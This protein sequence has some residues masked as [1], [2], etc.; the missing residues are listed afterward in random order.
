MCGTSPL[1]ETIKYHQLDTQELSSV[2]SESKY[3]IF[4]QENA[5]KNFVCKRWSFCWGFSVLS[6]RTNCNR[7]PMGLHLFAEKHRNKYFYQFSLRYIQSNFN[8]G[9][10]W[11]HFTRLQWSCTKTYDPSAFEHISKG[12]GITACT[13]QC[14]SPICDAPSWLVY[15]DDGG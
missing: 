7:H 12:Y 4:I 6:H 13:H 14:T 2:K 8:T 9:L 10:C 5:F 11:Y 15:A 1:T 3:K